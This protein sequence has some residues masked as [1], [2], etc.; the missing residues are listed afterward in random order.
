MK[1]YLSYLSFYL[2][3]LSFFLLSFL[4]A[5]ILCSMKE[6]EFYQILLKADEEHL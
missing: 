1:A 2:S 6:R 4:L 5:L 3:Y